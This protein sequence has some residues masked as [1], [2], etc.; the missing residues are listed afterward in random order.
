MYHSCENN[1]KIT[2][3][4]ENCLGTTCND[5]QSSS[6]KFLE[7]D[8]FLSIHEQNLQ[9]LTNEICKS[10]IGLSLSFMKDI[11]PINRNPC[12]LKKNSQFS[13]PRI[14]TLYQ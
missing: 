10:S 9:V 6:D 5:E 8:G 14:N 13:R 7:N 1:G 4:N 2:S 12:N 11:F 3:L